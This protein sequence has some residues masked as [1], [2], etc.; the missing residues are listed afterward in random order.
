MNNNNSRRAKAVQGKNNVEEAYKRYSQFPKVNLFK[1]D[2]LQA[3]REHKNL[4]EL[5]YK[6]LGL[7]RRN[8]KAFERLLKAIHNSGIHKK[9]QEKQKKINENN[10]KWKINFVK[11]SEESAR[12]RRPNNPNKFNVFRHNYRR[13]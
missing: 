7:L 8:A 5:L 1:K 4:R 12:A 3:A 6:N 9:L 2:L 13:G 10:K 11:R